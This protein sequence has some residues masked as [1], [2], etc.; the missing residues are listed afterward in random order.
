[1][2]QRSPIIFW[3]LLAA[4]LSVDALLGYLIF[5]DRN[6]AEQ[7]Q[8]A[9]YAMMISQLS[10]VCIWSATRPTK[11]MA[12][13]ISPLMAVAIEAATARRDGSAMNW[14]RLVDS[15]IMYG[16]HA[17]MLLVA[18]WVLQRTRFWQ[19][20]TRMPEPWRYSLA[21]L[22]VVMTVVAVLGGLLHLRPISSEDV[23]FAILFMFSSVALAVASVCIWSLSWH[24][25]LRLAATLGFAV[26]LGFASSLSLLIE[27][28]PTP[29]ASVFVFLLVA[30][31]LIQGIVLSVWL[32]CVPILPISHWAD[33]KPL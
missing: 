22:V 28:G 23:W 6:S 30:H 13:R 21:H 7:L 18:L 12:T 32:G 19:R 31:F 15:F 20:R 10:I 9:F 24:V 16:I 14:E 3:L 26:M 27:S 5:S 4:T 1:M 2:Q 8:T 11:T 17:A 25:I 33:A 29:L